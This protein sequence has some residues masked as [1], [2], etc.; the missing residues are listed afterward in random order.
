VGGVMV[1][2]GGIIFSGG[3]WDDCE[4]YLD[5]YC[6]KSATFYTTLGS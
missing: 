3:A 5:I 4:T 6:R 2:F 1:R